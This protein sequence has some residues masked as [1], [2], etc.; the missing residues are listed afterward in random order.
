[1]SNDVFFLGAGFSKAIDGSYPTLKELS[2]FVDV[3]IKEERNVSIKQHYENEIPTQLKDNVE[4]LL[5]YL[6]ADLP[7]KDGTQKHED[8]ALYEKIIEIIRWRFLGRFIASIREI[9]DIENGAELPDFDLID[10]VSAEK[11]YKYILKNNLFSDRKDIITLNYDLVSETYL[12]KYKIY[13]GIIQN[14][15]LYQIPIP[16]TGS[17]SG[18]GGFGAYGMPNTP[19][20]IKLH[21]SI[22]WYWS[23][24]STTDT[25]FCRPKDAKD[26]EILGLKPCIV[27]P[28]MDKTQYYDHSILRG[29]W[30]MAARKLRQANNIY[31]IG[32]SFPPTDLSVRFLFQSALR[33]SRARIIAVNIDESDNFKEIYKNIFGEKEIDYT[34]CGV[35][36]FKKFA[37]KL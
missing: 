1:M 10:D 14:D 23:G 17:R 2:E 35:D 21:G 25:I 11:F 34:Y 24:R 26:R 15:E 31:I 13:Q 5:S 22:N 3:V 29:L 18:V 36:A 7:W 30:E 28:V 32:F 6:S 12:N 16:Y 33:N 8:L 9:E 4:A 27:P 37:E 19:H 20:L